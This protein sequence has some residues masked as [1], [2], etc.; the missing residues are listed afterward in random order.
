MFLCEICNAANGSAFEIGQCHICGGKAMETPRMIE[1]A[2]ALLTKENAKSFSI[3]TKIPKDWL[4]REEDAWDVSMKGT[5]SLKSMLN[6][7]IV[8]AL[9][10]KSSLPYVMDGD[11][12]LVFDYKKGE[13]E[14]QRNDLFIFGRYLKHKAGLSQSRWLCMKCQGEGCNKCGGKGKNFESVEERIGE[15]V[16]RMAGSE[17]YVLHASGR[18]DVDATNS[19]G[20]AFVIEV[21]GPQTRELDL[22]K[23]AEDIAASGEVSVRDL[24]LVPRRFTESVTESHFDKSYKAGVE[25]GRELTEEDKR[26]IEGIAGQTLLQRTPKR[27]AHRRADLVRQRKV[28]EIEVLEFNGKTA[29]LRIKAEAGTY[30][31]ELI[32]SD[33]GRTEP[34]IAGL[35][36][37]E[38]KC[39]SLDV[40]EIDDDYLDFCIRD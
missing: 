11:V 2:K 1:E 22:V 9:K 32:S 33:G 15:P 27:V 28:K 29:V 34:S 25:F 7:T 12:R 30:I 5:E 40:S 31:K 8:R 35:L 6:G 13:V 3:S 14:L 37:T 4:V 10:E 16:K 18:E 20:R 23:L 24:R 21:K 19:A 17:D 26:K 39:A 38:A 36:A